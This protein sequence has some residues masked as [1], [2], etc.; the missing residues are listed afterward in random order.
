M[1]K[2]TSQSRAIRAGL[3]P[4]LLILLAVL[5]G[6]NGD[7]D[8][9]TVSGKVTHQGKVVAGEVVFVGLDKKQYACPITDEGTYKIKAPKGEFQVLVK[10]MPGTKRPEPK[11]AKKVAAP[12]A[13]PAPRGV[14]PP[15]K[16]L[17]PNNG[18]KVI[19][20]G[21]EQIFDIDLK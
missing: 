1:N 17:Q 5:S 20:T 11:T 4:G 2:C 19:V 14:A 18:L 16:Y 10:G 15:A 13:G 7:G 6:C 21:A 12:I 8:G 9:D 3:F